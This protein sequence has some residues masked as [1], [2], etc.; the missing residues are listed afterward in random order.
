MELKN[1]GA[2]IF[3]PDGLPV[4]K[5]LA[6][7]THMAL[8][9]HQDDLPIM[10]QH[11]I[12]ECFGQSDKW[13][14]GVTVTNG[15]GSPRDDLYAD[16]T[17]E[18]MRAVRAEEEKKAGF[19]GEYSAVVLLDYPSSAVKDPA[20]ADVTEEI[21]GLIAAARPSVIYVHN[22]AD[23]HD[24]HVAVT[25]RTLAAL[26]EL[27]AEARPE[28]VYGCEVWRDL[29]WMVD[30]DKVAFDVSSHENFA[31]ALMGI[32][33]SQVCGGKRYDLAT[34]G[35]RKAHATYHETHGVDVAEAIIFA[36]DLTPLIA[37][38]DVDVTAYV[39]EHI[40]RFAA[41]VAERIAKLT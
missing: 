14:L 9:A 25:L 22:L 12:L 15:S 29:D 27:P 38:T 20:N 18:Q 24:T 8:G 31:A 23:K 16:Y 35:R 21:K 13:F 30:E 34:A 6:R 3:V 17:D 32:Y 41:D 40:N 36:M 4:D 33:D 2:Q 19:V 28:A 11:G 7:S 1:E 10:A 5:A 26:R 37:D 39:N